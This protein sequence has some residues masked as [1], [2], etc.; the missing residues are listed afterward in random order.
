M[1]TITLLCMRIQQILPEP[2]IIVALIIMVFMPHK[3]IH[4][5]AMERCGSMTEKGFKRFSIISI[6]GLFFLFL[7]IHSVQYPNLPDAPSPKTIDKQFNTDIAG[8][9]EHWK[10][11]IE[12]KI[13]GTEIYCYYVG[14]DDKAIINPVVRLCKKP[15][16]S[17]PKRS[18]Y[19]FINETEWDGLNI[20]VYKFK[21]G[22]TYYPYFVITFNDEDGYYNIRTEID[23]EYMDGETL[24]EE[25][26]QR[27]RT[28]AD[29]VKK[30]N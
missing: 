1:E 21:D 8:F 17:K 2:S 23:A 30:R 29:Q 28:I 7:Y 11:N 10:G 18:Y 14:T 26:L 27:I 22:G 9:A 15:F 13:D 5:G 24:R 3:L 19:T 4:A 12:K 20:S 25:D 16:E 6:I